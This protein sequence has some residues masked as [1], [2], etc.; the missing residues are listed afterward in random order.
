MPHDY[1]T[2]KSG[3][4]ILVALDRIKVG[5]PMFE[6]RFGHLTKDV[7]NL[8]RE[9][10]KKSHDAIFTADYL[11]KRVMYNFLYKSPIT[12]W[13]VRVKWE[14]EKKNFE[15][16][17]RVIGDRKRIYDIGCGLGYLGYFLHYRGLDRVITGVDYDEDKIA[18]AA[19]GYDKSDNLIFEHGDV[20][21]LNIKDADAVFFN[22]VLHYM[23][24]EQQMSVL[25]KTVDRLS[26]E[27]MILIRDGITDLEER[28]FVTEKTERYSTQI[29][30]FN[31][32]TDALSFFSSKDIFNFANKEGLNCEMIEQS[33]KNSNVLF[34]LRKRAD[35]Q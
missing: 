2:I 27:G 35:E 20:R 5:D 19:N 23:E 28:H 10:Q 7:C 13:Y 14:L 31:K 3:S 11:K 8:M 32:T 26:N 15:I 33:K 17:D 1:P 16:Y 9:Q 25:K 4:L 29:I 21:S 24:R 18:I 12:E 30:G 6:Q 34:I 22:D